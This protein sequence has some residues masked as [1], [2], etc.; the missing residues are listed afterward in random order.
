MKL[1]AGL[2]VKQYWSA[3]DAPGE[4]GWW[5]GTIINKKPGFGQLCAVRYS[6][7][8]EM[9]VTKAEEATFRSTLLAHTLSL[10]KPAAAKIKPAFAYI[11][12]R[13][14]NTCEPQYH[15]KDQHNNMRLL[16]IFD[17][18]FAAELTLAELEDYLTELQHFPPFCMHDLVPAMKADAKSE[19]FHY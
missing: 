18:S 17:P 8:S 19:R 13:L 11:T 10:W 5:E 1:E 14:E 6:N 9:W 16:Q 2:Q 7:G 4:S 3:T 12:S 15:M